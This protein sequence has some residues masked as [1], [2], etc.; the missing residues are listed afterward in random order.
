MHIYK[1]AK[2]RKS[3]KNYVMNAGGMQVYFQMKAN[4]CFLRKFS[5]SHQSLVLNIRCGE[6]EGHPLNKIQVCVINC[7]K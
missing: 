3:K 7:M 2:Q 4:V 1:T 5:Y 6:V